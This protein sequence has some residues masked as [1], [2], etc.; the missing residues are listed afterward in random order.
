MRLRTGNAATVPAAA[1]ALPCGH[2]GTT[3]RAELTAWAC[4]VCGWEAAR[5]DSTGLIR[6][7]D[8]PGNRIVALVTGATI[9]NAILLLALA[10]AVARAG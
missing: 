1:V 9:A 5:P 10:M 2:C 7:L 3:F 8:D 6:W 4:P